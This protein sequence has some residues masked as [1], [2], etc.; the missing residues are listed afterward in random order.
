MYGELVLK[1]R[2]H[3]LVD[4]MYHACNSH[5][6]E[7]RRASTQTIQVLVYHFCCICSSSCILQLDVVFS[8]PSLRYLSRW[9]NDPQQQQQVEGDD[10]E[11]VH[12]DGL[13]WVV[14]P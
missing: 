4:L 8:C 13:M 3:L 12:G 7:G 11:V 5:L 1:R 2:L 10:S 14:Y 6:L 9:P